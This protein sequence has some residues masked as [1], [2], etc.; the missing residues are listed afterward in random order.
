MATLEARIAALEGGKRVGCLAC[1]LMSI[2][3]PKDWPRPPCTHPPTT[4]ARELIGLNGLA[5]DEQPPRP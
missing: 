4:L 5:E 3:S 1:E 2:D